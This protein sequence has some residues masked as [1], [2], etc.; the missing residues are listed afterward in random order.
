MRPLRFIHAADTHLD[1]AFTGLSLVDTEVSA[2]LQGATFTALERLFDLCLAERPDFLIIAGD[3]TNAEDRSLQ[4]QWALHAGCVRLAAV[5]IPVLIV[6]GN[7]DPLTSRLHTL[8]WPDTVTFFGTDVESVPIYASS[9]NGLAN[10]FPDTLP[11]GLPNGLANGLPDTLPNGLP[12]DLP[13]DSP[14]AL[15][16]ALAR[17]CIAVVHGVSYG[18]ASEKRNLAKKFSRGD[19]ACPHIGIL[20]TNLGETDGVNSYAPCTLE[21]LQKA[22]MDYWALG[23]IHKR[24]VLCE[25]PP[26]VYAG[27]TQGLHILEEG[28]KGCL[29][30]TLRP[31]TLSLTP[32]YICERQFH[33][34]SEVVW[35]TIDVPVELEETLDSLDTRLQQILAKAHASMTPPSEMLIVRLRLTGRTHLDSRLRQQES[36]DSLAERANFA[37]SV[38]HSGYGTAHSGYGAAHSGYGAAHSVWVK[39]IQAHTRPA[40]DMEALR[41]RRDLPGEISRLVATWQD[42]PESLQACRAVLQDLF[43]RK[44]IHKMVQPLSDEDLALMLADAEALCL[45]MMEKS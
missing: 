32:S 36:L 16:N 5:N 27:C 28:E 4:A 10:G 2:R 44:T 9:E 45:D 35:R 17:E 13:D 14:N 12:N 20:H 39:D 19:E 25:T 1:A 29:L 31:D 40:I 26:I 33:S 21:D 37:P 6:H 38:A 15:P 7:H 30:V 34:L 43:A 3:V 11:N 41:T 18:S 42:D 24:Q 8:Q 22:G 23:H